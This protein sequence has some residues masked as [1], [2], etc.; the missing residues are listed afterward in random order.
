LPTGGHM[1]TALRLPP[2]L[3]TFLD[4]PGPQTLVL[5]GPP[6]SG[7]S[8]LSLAM[9][10]AFRGDRLLVTS[11]VPN[12][13]ILREFPWLGENGHRQIQTFDTSELDETV[14]NMARM[15]EQSRQYLFVPQIAEEREVSR[16]LWLPPPLQEAW[17]RLNPDRPALIVIDSWDALIE[18]YLSPSE[19]GARAVPD[20]SEI[21]RLLLRRMSRSAAHLVFVLEREQQ[22]ALDYLVNGVVVLQRDAVHERLQRWATLFKLRGVRI[23]NPVYPFTLESAKFESIL[24]AKPY[25]SLRSRPPD[26]EP[27]AVPDHLWPGSRAFAENFGRL[28][29]GKSTLL[30]LDESVPSRVADLLVAPAIAHN[31]HKGGHVLVTPDPSDTPDDV[32]ASLADSVPMHRFVT[33]AR[34]VVPPGGRPSDA[35]EAWKTAKDAVGPLVGS[36]PHDPESRETV[37]FV[38]E[39]AS[40]EAPGLMVVSVAGILSAAAAAGNPYT[41]ESIHQIPVILMSAVRGAPVHAIVI[42]R[43]GSPILGPLRVNAT[44]RVAVEFHQGRVFVHGVSPWTPNF[45]LTDGTG[46][47]PYDLLRVV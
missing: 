11:R 18:Q 5:R 30:E 7:K 10:E 32:F 14:H 17:S 3:R 6:G 24:P 4:L 20:R 2:E 35:T 43:E 37:R 42:A 15:I 25:G 29:L 38:R 44:T 40:P 22:T 21:E 36:S 27:D 34:I 31:L 45:V 8:T 33:H 1:S 47:S 46:D 19:G 16:F 13:E 28:A 12:R 26:P 23:E 41:G 39:G 9:L